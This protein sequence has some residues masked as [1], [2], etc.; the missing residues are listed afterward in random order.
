M[1]FSSGK[2]ISLVA[3]RETNF[4]FPYMG[5]ER[6]EYVEDAIK[7]ETDTF[8][9]LIWDSDPKA[10]ERVSKAMDTLLSIPLYGI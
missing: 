3:T 10:S 9:S 6:V 8:Y 4:L 5:L 7:L 2:T 1:G